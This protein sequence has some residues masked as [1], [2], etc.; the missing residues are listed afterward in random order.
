LSPD[1]GVS[2]RCG[3]LR[4]LSWQEDQAKDR[5][6]DEQADAD[7]RSGDEGVSGHGIAAPPARELPE[8]WFSLL[9]QYL[10][11]KRDTVPAHD[12]FATVTAVL[13]ELDGI[14]LV[15]LGVHNSSGRS[16][17]HAQAAGR[18]LDEQYGPFGLDASFPFYVWIR[19]SDGGWHTAPPADW[20][21][22]SGSHLIL[23]GRRPGG[24]GERALTLRL[25]PPLA[26]STPWIEVLA[27]GRSAEVRA[28]LPL[29][30]GPSP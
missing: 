23:G 28:G 30:W 22:D 15:L 9:A 17:L 25:V 18:V 1:F 13:P 2:L 10:R 3:G 12:G 20:F 21:P 6:D 26:R 4:R 8:P 24:A 29:R 5:A 16:W 11:R 27:G 19:D 14:R 7:G